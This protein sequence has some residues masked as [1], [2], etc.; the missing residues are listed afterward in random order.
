M[1]AFSAK[2]DKLVMMKEKGLLSDEEFAVL[3]KN[4]I[5]SI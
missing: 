2:L 1:S 4:L 5:E 3:K